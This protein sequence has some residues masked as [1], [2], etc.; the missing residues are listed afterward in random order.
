MEKEVTVRCRKS[1][2]ELVQKAK[3]AASSEFKENAGLELNL[4]VTEDLPE[5]S[6]VFINQYLHGQLLANHTRNP[7]CWRCYH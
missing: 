1:D 2:S 5:E 3:D 6:C 7:Q 4:N